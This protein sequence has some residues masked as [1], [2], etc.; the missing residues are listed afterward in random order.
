MIFYDWFVIGLSYW[1]HVYAS[2]RMHH[3]HH[4]KWPFSRLW[5]LWSWSCISICL[6]TGYNTLQVYVVVCL[7]GGAN[8]LTNLPSGPNSAPE[9]G[10]QI[11]NCVA[12]LLT[13]SRTKFLVEYHS[14]CLESEFILQRLRGSCW[15]WLPQKK[16]K[17]QLWIGLLHLYRNSEN[18]GGREHGALR[19]IN[20]GFVSQ[21]DWGKSR[22]G[23]FHG[24]T[25]H[26]G[27]LWIKLQSPVVF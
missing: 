1:V 14:S 19:R 20:K 12:T 10:I 11:M 2:C 9:G 17:V 27:M 4:D 26:L 7:R 6:Q 3:W 13:K 25:N 16:K 24:W 22:K 18:A 8:V 15:N 23:A 21:P 5:L